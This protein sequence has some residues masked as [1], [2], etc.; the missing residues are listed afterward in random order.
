M[1]MQSN[2]HNELTPRSVLPPLFW[3]PLTAQST[4][5]NIVP[6][7]Q[8]GR[9]IRHA[10]VTVALWTYWQKT[11]CNQWRSRKVEWHYRTSGQRKPFSLA[12]ALMTD[13]SLS[14]SWRGRPARV[15]LRIRRY[16]SIRFCPQPHRYRMERAG[17]SLMKIVIVIIQCLCCCL[18][19]SGPLQCFINDS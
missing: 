1:F 16:S 2:G 3:A 8:L 9:C 17:S 12:A 10:R 6:C 4:K 14:S 5:R 11:G 15:A 7:T 13:W 18:M 19:T